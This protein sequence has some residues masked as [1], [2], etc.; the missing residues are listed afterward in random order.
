MRYVALVAGHTYCSPLQRE[1]LARGEDRKSYNYLVCLRSLAQCLFDSNAYTG[2]ASYPA[3]DPAASF[4][5]F[6]A[7]YPYHILLRRDTKLEMLLCSL[8]SSL[9]ASE[10][11]LAVLEVHGWPRNHGLRSPK[12]LSV[13]RSFVKVELMIRAGTAT[14]VRFRGLSPTT[15]RSAPS[16]RRRPPR[17]RRRLLRLSFCCIFVLFVRT[18]LAGAIFCL[19]QFSDKLHSFSTYSSSNCEHLNGYPIQ[20]HARSEVRGE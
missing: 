19:E 12:D 1:Y 15:H 6:P 3:F 11:P 9:L 8:Q 4:D 10:M 16:S 7:L 17:A 14:G 18:T 13:Q 2:V 5:I 20:Q